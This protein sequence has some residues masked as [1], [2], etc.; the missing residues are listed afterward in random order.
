MDINTIRPSSVQ[1]TQ[2]IQP[3]IKPESTTK[4]IGT[5]FE[6]A[7]NSLSQSQTNSDQLIEK[8]AAGENVDVHQVMIASE[9]TDINFRIA[10]AIRDKLV[11][12]YR[13]VMRMT[14]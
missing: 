14:V 9:E 11:E 2:K 7:L 5:T 10:L 1:S 8:L 4:Q 6:Q 13:E 12:S 3:E